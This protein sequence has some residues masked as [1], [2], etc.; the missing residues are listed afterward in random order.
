MSRPPPSTYRTRNWPAYNAA[1]KRRG[2]LTIHGPAG[3]CQA[4]S[5]EVGARSTSGSTR[6][7]W[8]S[9]P[10]KSPGATS[11]MRRC[12]PICSARSRQARRSA[13]SPQTAPRVPCLQVRCV[14]RAPLNFDQPRGP[15]T[16]HFVIL[17]QTAE[18][19]D[20]VQGAGL[21]QREV[22]DALAF[23]GSNSLWCSSGVLSI[24]NLGMAPG[25][26]PLIR[27]RHGRCLL[28]TPDGR[29][30]AMSD[31]RSAVFRSNRL[32]GSG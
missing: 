7:R 24:E 14:D 6:K 32:D 2:S 31:C 21:L 3:H 19:L 12:C 16:Q 4:M 25:S 8:R 30:Q 28:P 26:G 11:A 22:L 1:R 13:A 20:L 29:E 18:K 23:Q 10:S 9:A 17:D 15:V 27:F 5:R